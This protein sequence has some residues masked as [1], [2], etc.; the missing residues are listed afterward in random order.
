VG[1]NRAQ[2]NPDGVK[3]DDLLAGAVAHIDEHPEAARVDELK[4]GAVDLDRVARVRVGAP[5]DFAK[6][7][8]LD[9]D[10][11]AE[12]YSPSI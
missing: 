1:V 7:L 5:D 3:Q 9:F 12:I 8:I 4:S 2:G 10:G 11:V 6:K